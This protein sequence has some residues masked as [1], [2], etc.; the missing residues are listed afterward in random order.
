M[1]ALCLDCRTRFNPREDYEIRCFGC[2]KVWKNARGEHR[3][4]AT[5]APS[6]ILPAPAEWKEILPKLIRLTHPDRHANSPASNAVT[7]WLLA[8]R[9]RMLAGS[10]R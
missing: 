10:P 2:W 3:P 6:P 8:Q 4:N 9:K 7:Q 1:I 5:H